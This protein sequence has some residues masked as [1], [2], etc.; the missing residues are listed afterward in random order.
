MFR[1]VEYSFWLFPLVLFLF[2]ICSL[3][4]V[5]S[6][7]VCPCFWFNAFNITLFSYWKVLGQKRKTSSCIL[8][9]SSARTFPVVLACLL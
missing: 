1:G 5:P 9:K 2:D 6:T 8:G 4:I 7:W 3:C